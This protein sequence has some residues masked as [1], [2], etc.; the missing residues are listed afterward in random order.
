MFFLPFFY[1]FCFFFNYFLTHFI[2]FF[3]ILF[4]RFRMVGRNQNISN[5]CERV[6]LGNCFS[7]GS[8]RS[9]RAKNKDEH[10]EGGGKEERKRHF[11]CGFQNVITILKQFS[12]WLFLSFFSLFWV[13]SFPMN[14]IIYNQNPSFSRIFCNFSKYGNF[15]LGSLNR[16]IFKK[17]SF[18]YFEFGI[19]QKKMVTIFFL[20]GWD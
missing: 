7:D 11:L 9:G 15:F 8:F 14:L 5:L 19:F 16:K 3:V 1:Y 4:M 18:Q 13:S 6:A 20:L 10:E 17:S 2:L 12:I